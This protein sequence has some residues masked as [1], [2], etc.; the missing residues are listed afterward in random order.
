MILYILK[1][2][3]C[4]ALLLAFYHLVLEREKMHRFN[5]F[6]LLGSILF[7]F[8]APAFI[9][10]VEAIPTVLET[11]PTTLNESGFNVQEGVSTTS[12]PID[13][14][15][16]YITY[17]FWL[18]G[19]ISSVLLIRFF[20]SLFHII[21]KI[22]RNQKTTYSNAIIVLVN[23]EILPHTFWN[24]IFINKTSFNAKEIEEELFTHELTHVTQRHTIDVLLIEA[25]QILFWINPLFFLLKKAVQ[26][27][28]EFLADDSV[29]A[30]HNNI[31]EYQYLLLN[32]A[33]W[34]NEYYL[35]S[36]LNYS[37]TKKRL[38]MMKKSNSTASI[39][40]KKLAIIPL[41]T[42]LVFLFANRVE[43]QAT[44]KK[45]L[46][47]EVPFE[48]I[49]E[50]EIYRDF[51]NRY[52]VIK[53]DDTEG[54]KISKTYEELSSKEKDQFILPPPPLTSQKKTP[55]KKLI[56]DLKNKEKY[57]VWIDG[58]VINNTTLSNFE[59]TDFSNYFGSF[60]HKNARSKRFPQQHQFSLY[61][62][63]HFEDS[64]AK[65]KKAFEDF[66]KE[67]KTYKLTGKDSKKGIANKGIKIISSASNPKF[68]KDWY[69][70]IDRQKYYYT[71]DK[72]ERVARY[73]KNG[74]LTNLDIVKEYKK[75]NELVAKL[76]NKGVHYIKKSKAERKRIDREYSDLGG[77]YFRMNISDKKQ[78]TRPKNP[79]R[80]YT[81]LIKKDGVVYYKLRAEL[82]DEDHKNLMPP[83]PF[84]NASEAQKA[85]I[86]ARLKE[87]SKRLKLIKKDN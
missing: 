18:Y 47:E 40:L 32:K 15:I 43:A 53:Y 82:T 49:N 34:K 2:G 58:T 35:T 55:S 74:K 51:A 44:K 87:W 80:P 42:G 50:K 77:M 9:I 72:K 39:L 25:L 69:F 41:F 79:I 78:V 67:Y 66:K 30:S 4:L 38:E 14:S 7:S 29:I 27:N 70:T 68:N 5:R 10:Y 76:K 16:N 8:L 22:R 1:S 75:K 54:N 28:H 23:D 63:K 19:L 37:L 12:I 11:V 48:Q 31:S 36:N 64:N 17:F 33:A 83:P 3:L 26:L 86:N 73:Y 59:N 81:K 6:Y 62:N 60:I 71:F 24:Y 46:T 65:K 61:T 21:Q 57:A 13:E 85:D 52:T 84:P 45:Q 20:K 56:D